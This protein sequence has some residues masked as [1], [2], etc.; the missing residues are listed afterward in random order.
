MSI[1]A[2]GWRPVRLVSAAGHEPPPNEPISVV[3]GEGH[4]CGFGHTPSPGSRNTRQ[5]RC[6][7]WYTYTGWTW[8]PVSAAGLLMSGFAR[9][10]GSEWHSLDDDHRSWASDHGGL[11]RRLWWQALIVW[12]EITGRRA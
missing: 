5:C 7:T 12:W 2:A 9:R 6:G 3:T 4:I 1:L 8:R 10:D 11:P